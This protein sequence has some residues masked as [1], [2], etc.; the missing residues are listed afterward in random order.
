MDSRKPVACKI[1]GKVFLVYPSRLKLGKVGFCSKKCKG[2]Y[3]TSI[4]ALEFTCVIC[5][6]KFQCTIGQHKQGHGV[7]CSVECRNIHLSRIKSGTRVKPRL[8]RK[9]RNC[10]AQIET[11]RARD[12]KYCSCKCYASRNQNGS[13]NH[14]WNGGTSFEPHTPEFNGHLKKYIRDRDRRRCSVCNKRWIRGNTEYPVHHI[15][16]NKADSRPKN[17]ITV[18]HSCHGKTNTRR[19]EWEKVL[20]PLARQREQLPRTMA[21]R[22]TMYSGHTS[23]RP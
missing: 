9:C 8:K 14:F 7:T 3:F 15:N 6:K 17:L 20:S 10:K 11:T 23:G 12:R 2:K 5:G 21:L 13:R 1:C 4:N 16:Y 22:C 18:C 19:K